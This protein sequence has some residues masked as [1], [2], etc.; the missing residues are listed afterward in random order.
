MELWKPIPGLPGYEAS[1]FGRIRSLPKVVAIHHGYTRKQQI[2]LLKAKPDK[3]GYLRVKAG[4]KLH[5]VHRLVAKAFIP[6][7]KNKPEVNHKDGVKAHCWKGNLE[8]ATTKEN[9]DHAVVNGLK[10]GAWTKT[11]PKSKIVA[12]A[13]K[14]LRAEGLSQKTIGAL[15]GVSQQTVSNV[16]KSW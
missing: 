12:F 4:G 10:R 15:V 5:G 8:W 13:V 9:S 2:R 11:T 1:I 6:N 16:L 3:K 14:K 7:P